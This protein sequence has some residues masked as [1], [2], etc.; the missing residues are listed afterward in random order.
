MNKYNYITVLSNWLLGYDKYSNQYKKDLLSKSTYP[1]EF[2]LLKEN[3]LYIGIEKANKLLNK[4]NIANNLLIRIE[5]LLDENLVHKNIKNG[6][7]YFINQNY[8]PIHKIFFYIDNV[9]KEQI[10]EE[11]NAL[12][13][14][15]QSDDLYNYAELT[16]RTLSILPIASACQAKCKFCFSETSISYDQKN[17]Q[18]DFENLKSLCV[19]AKLNGAER[20]VITGGGEPT[21]LKFSNLLNIIEIAKKHFN[22]IVLI[23][24]GLFLSKLSEE[25][26]NKKLTSLIETGLTTLCISYHHYNEFKNADI[27]GINTSITNLILNINKHPLRNKIKLRLIC[28]LQKNYIDTVPEINNYINFALNLNV[29]QVCFKELYVASTNESLYS[30][31]KENEYCLTHQTPL[32][33]VINWAKCNNLVFKSKLPWGSPVFTYTKDSKDIEIVA[34]TEPSVGWEKLNKIARSWN[35]LSDGKCYVSLEDKNSLIN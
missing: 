6:K 29:E 25:E 8:I 9:W 13:Y 35:I 16:P 22:K 23:T 28:V 1:N 30:N 33:E 12:S 2:Y 14:L 3:E 7:G 17:S 31:S 32:S 19:L 21:I 20:F 34:Y 18:I 15:L 11:V 24:N 26:M 27:M 10:I 4:L 5:T